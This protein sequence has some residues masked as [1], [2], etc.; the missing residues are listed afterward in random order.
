MTNGDN[1][2]PQ[3]DKNQASPQLQDESSPLGSTPEESE[4]I[5]KTLESVGLP[6]DDDGPRELNSQEVIDRADKD[7]N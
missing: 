4:D 6:S 7:Q 1:F 2:D 5:D 3:D